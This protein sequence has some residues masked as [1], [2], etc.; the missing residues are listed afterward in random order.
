MSRENLK[1]YYYI[2]Q[3]EDTGKWEVHANE[4]Y[5]G[6]PVINSYDLEKDAIKEAEEKNDKIKEFLEGYF[7]KELSKPF[8][9]EESY[10]KL[11]EILYCDP[12]YIVVL[13]NEVGTEFHCND[14][15]MDEEKL[16]VNQ[17]VLEVQI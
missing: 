13:E 14:I 9:V 4:Y 11:K 6:Y 8:M 1:G 16:E 2:E 5:D 7:K 15:F 10:F 17:Y 3:D 12:M